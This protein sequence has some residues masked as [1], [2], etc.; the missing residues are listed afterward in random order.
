VNAQ[1]SQRRNKNLKTVLAVLPGTMRGDK[2]LAGSVLFATDKI[3]LCPAPSRR[4]QR[5]INL[6]D[7]NLKF[8]GH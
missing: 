4:A 5:I 3:R 8:I 6:H 2:T 1:P 7:L